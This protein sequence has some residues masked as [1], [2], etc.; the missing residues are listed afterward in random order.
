MYIVLQTVSIERR[1][2]DTLVDFL[3]SV[4][5]AKVTFIGQHAGV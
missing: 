5:T 1:L 4:T 3:K 2:F